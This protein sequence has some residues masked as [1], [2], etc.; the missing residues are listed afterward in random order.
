MIV[1]DENIHL[2]QRERLSGWRIRFRHIGTDL[3][4]QGADDRAHIIPLL[5]RL[6]RATFFSGDRD[7][8][9]RDFR[10][11]RY[12]IVFLDVARGERAR[13]IRRLLRHP[14]FRTF[15]QRQGTVVHVGYGGIR[16]WRLN[17]EAEEYSSWPDEA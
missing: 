10:H 3:L 16:A 9:A 11:Q 7:F 15:S 13:F 8:Y 5:H 14:H 4:Q 2:D 17:A 1:L 12:C 6:A